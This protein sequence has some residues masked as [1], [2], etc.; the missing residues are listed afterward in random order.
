MRRIESVWFRGTFFIHLFLHCR[1]YTHSLE[2]SYIISKQPAC[3]P[4]TLYAAPASR[5][6]PYNTPQKHILPYLTRFFFFNN[7]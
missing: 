4:S 7:S 5:V 2:F 1:Y 6:I 3:L